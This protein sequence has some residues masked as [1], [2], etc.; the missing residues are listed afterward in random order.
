MKHIKILLVDDEPWFVDALAQR[1]SLR[2]FSVVVAYDGGSALDK[3]ESGEYSAVL[4]D[5]QLPDMH[6]TEV[7]R[8]MRHSGNQTRVIIVTAHGA[9]EDQEKCRALGAAG[10][11]NKPARIDMIEKMLMPDPGAE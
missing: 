11:L 7:L 3:L 8:R 10:F 9:R 5:L 6:G 4:L 1:L 2:G